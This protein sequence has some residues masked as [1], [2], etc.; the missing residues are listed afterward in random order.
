MCLRIVT[1]STTTSRRTILVV[2]KALTVELQTLRLGAVAW[3]VLFH[4]R[5]LNDRLSA[6]FN[7]IF[8][9]SLRFHL[10]HRLLVILVLC[11]LHVIDALLVLF[12]VLLRWLDLGQ[13]SSGQLDFVDR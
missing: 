6:L 3:L 7:V 9:I 11:A 1:A 12:I 8:Q 13:N 10:A 4:G 2:R 5:C